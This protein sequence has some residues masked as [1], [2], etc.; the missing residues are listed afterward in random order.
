MCV[1][2]PAEQSR[3]L[4]R[5]RVSSGRAVAEGDQVLPLL[6]QARKGND[7]A[8]QGIGELAHRLTGT[9]GSCGFMEVT[10]AAAAIVAV[11]E[12]GAGASRARRE[13]VKHPVAER[14]YLLLLATGQ[15]DEGSLS[16][17]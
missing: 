5:G 15:P 13:R 8:L 12:T 1:H 2:P 14:A 6:Q 11:V 17:L 4:P 16:R 7:Q 3:L 10:S 9:A